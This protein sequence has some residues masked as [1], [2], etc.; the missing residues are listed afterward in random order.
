MEHR[1]TSGGAQLHYEVDGPPDAPALLLV[2][3]IGTTTELWSRQLPGLKAAFRVIR[4]DARGHGDSSTPTGEYTIDE[5]GRDALAVLDA[6]GAATAHVCGISLGGL[7]AMWLGIHAPDRIVSLVL[8]NTA[9]RPGA[10]ERWAERITL[11]QTHG[12]GAIAERVI[13]LWFSQEFRLRD[14]DSVHGFRAMLH[15]CRAEGYIGCCAALRDADLRA[16]APA[17]RCPVLV[18]SS[19]G[20]TVTPPEQAEQLRDSVPD[21]AFLMLT[22]GHLSNVEQAEPFTTAVVEF[23]GRHA[24]AKT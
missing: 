10:P 7:T 23:V 13:P 19:D 16:Q 18:I 12:M 2:N 9:G 15:D 14:P 24:A 6:A 8:A 11:I 1:V 3:A 17:I 21:A 5:L 4:Y 20:D 22:G